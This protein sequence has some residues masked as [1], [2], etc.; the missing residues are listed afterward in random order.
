MRYIIAY[1]IA[2][3]KRLRR[4]ARILEKHALRI[5][6]SVFLFQGT[7]EKL[8]EVIDLI[9]HEIDH[10]ADIVQAWIVGKEDHSTQTSLGRKLENTPIAV[11]LHADQRILIQDNKSKR[12]SRKPTI[13][14]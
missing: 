5:Q 6:K 9:S 13:K 3:P 12:N 8:R 10:E 2:H 14:S 11:V 4:V 1:D 7:E